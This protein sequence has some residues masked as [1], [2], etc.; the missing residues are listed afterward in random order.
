MSNVRRLSSH[1]PPSI[2]KGNSLHTSY[3]LFACLL[4]LGACASPPQSGLQDS[5]RIS[6]AECCKSIADINPALIKT[7]ELKEVSVSGQLP[8]LAVAG[9][10]TQV[11][12]L[13]VDL[14]SQPK[15]VE[16]QTTKE[17]LN[18]L[19][20][21]YQKVFVPT[22][23]FYDDAYKLLSS[24]EPT[25]YESVHRLKDTVWFRSTYYGAALV[26]GGAKYMAVHT[27]SAQLSTKVPALCNAGAGAF[28]ADKEDRKFF[29]PFAPLDFAT[30]PLSPPSQG[31]CHIQLDRAETGSVLLRLSS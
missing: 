24:S 23:A 7:L 15:L 19:G 9:G 3:S 5:S 1:S 11:A 18:I 25:L 13:Q 2:H 22:L 21:R 26:P 4:L 28:F 20:G 27:N 16:I 17:G 29:Q 30:K 12:V 8:K 10:T 31:L 14:S 6:T